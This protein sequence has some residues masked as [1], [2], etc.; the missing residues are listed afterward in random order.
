MGTPDDDGSPPGEHLAEVLPLDRASV[1]DPVPAPGHGLP[2]FLSSFVGRSREID[3]VVTLLG[4]ARLVTLTGPG[5]MGKTRLAVEVAQRVAFGRAFFVDLAPVREATLVAE[6]IASAFTVGELR[7]RDLAEVLAVALP[8]GALL[9]LDNCEHLIGVCADLADRLLRGCRGLQVLATSQQRLGMTGE[10]VWSVPAL[11][12]PELAPEVDPEAVLGS[13]AVQL[14]CHRAA[15]VKRGFVASGENLQ[16]IVEICRRLDGNPLAIELAA[17]RADVVSAADIAARLEDRFGLLRGG[18]GAGPARHQTLTA[19]LEWSHELLSESERVLL[20]RLSVFCGGFSLH[21][22]EEVCVGGEV[23]R[24]QM[25]DLLSGLVAKSLVVA[26]TGGTTARYRLLETVRHYAAEG[27]AATEATEVGRRHAA[28]CV[29]MVEFGAEEEDATDWL[30]ENQVELDNARAA[31][32]W[33][34]TEGETELALRLVGGLMVFWE[35]SG[36]FGEAR[37]HLLRVL[38]ASGSAPAALRATALHDTGFAEF[39]LGDFKAALDH[40]RESLAVSAEGGDPAAA[41]RTQGLLAF[42]STFGDNPTSVEELEENL[43]QVRAAGDDARLTETLIACG[44]ARR[45]RGECLASQQHFAEVVAV[46]RRTDDD[47]MLA[48]GLVGFGSAAVGRGDCVLAEAHLR[49]GVELAAGTA[50]AHSHAV[51]L[52]E[53]AELARLRGDRDQA[54]TSFIECL[55]HAR[56]VGAPYPL[57]KS[58]LGLGRV[59]LD[60]DEVENAQRH[61]D[62]AAEVSRQGGLAHLVASALDGLGQVASASG[63]T[64]SARDRFAEALAVASQCGDKAASARSTYH[65]GALA[66]A[67]GDFE[68]ATSLHHDAL[69]QRDLIGDRAGV[70][71]SLEALARL[72]GVRADYDLAARLFGA[73]QA[74]R[75]AG[76]CPR[77][78]R[79]GETSDAD[80][81]LLAEQM[82][83]E[84]LERAWGQGEALEYREAVAYATQRRGTRR[85]PATGLAS[86]TPAERDVAALIAEGLSNPEIGGRLF[87]SPRTVQS[88]LRNV[89]AKLDVTSRQELRQVLSGV[90]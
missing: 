50:Q 10:V 24:H 8:A 59:E 2:A 60:Q 4:S 71:D 30:A 25:L 77:A 72:A 76:G 19:A 38:A 82:T 3:E 6:E 88:H 43:A 9:V 84:D 47:V 41:E 79:R 69:S 55:D 14:F 89:Y 85:R 54:C 87:V 12:I 53:L 18:S 26:D 7:G 78:P 45:F 80:V 15:A 67:E 31:L 57:A 51:G 27:L 20:R 39:M 75:E 40:L 21:A 35:G 66:R 58:L 42:V 86:L 33:C 90:A 28:W 83:P 16:A 70:A 61:F 11:S 1:A 17:A 23:D 13:A 63:D 37:D 73:T 44:Q 48:T 56:A 5:G 68:K 49:E 32:N 29:E 46:A 81:A 64:A 62:E 74:L 65:Q 52:A 22:A 36:H 34:L